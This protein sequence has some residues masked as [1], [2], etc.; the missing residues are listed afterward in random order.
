MSWDWN[1]VDFSK[2]IDVKV[3][4][5]LNFDVDVDVKKETDIDVKVNADADVKGNTAELTLSVEAYGY[6]TYTQADV[7]ILT[8]EDQLSSIDLYAVSAVN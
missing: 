2:D 5:D 8:M 6:D 4:T 1:D 7:A 3:D